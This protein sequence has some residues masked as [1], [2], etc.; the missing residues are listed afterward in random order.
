MPAVQSL[1]GVIKCAYVPRTLLTEPGAYSTASSAFGRLDKLLQ[2]TAQQ[3]P[4]G[5]RAGFMRRACFREGRV[6]DKNLGKIVA[7]PSVYTNF[8][9]WD[10]TR[11][12]QILVETGAKN[13]VDALPHR[14]RVF[15]CILNVTFSYASREEA[16]KMLEAFDGKFLFP[17]D[18]DSDEPLIQVMN[19]SYKV[20]KEGKNALQWAFGVLKKRKVLGVNDGG[21]AFELPYDAG[22]SLKILLH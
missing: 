5:Y 3:F 20:T 17:L 12:E 11:G 13:L 21:C 22:S 9:T 6:V 2:Q 1:Q 4:E 8:T 18:K 14:L 19:E 10:K 15:L 16:K 7:E